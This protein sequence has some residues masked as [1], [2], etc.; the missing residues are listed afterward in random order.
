MSNKSCKRKQLKNNKKLSISNSSDDS[1]SDDKIISKLKL[2]YKHV[3]DA[4][5]QYQLFPNFEPIP[6]VDFMSLYPQSISD[7]PTAAAF[8]NDL[9][10]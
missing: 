5:K 2:K 3:L 4:M 1:N 9:D 7:D 6:C 10:D 8:Y